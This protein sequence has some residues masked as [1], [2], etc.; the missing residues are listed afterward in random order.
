MVLWAYFDLYLDQY[1]LSNKLL[2]FFVGYMSDTELVV[3]VHH[4][5]SIS[6]LSRILDLFSV[7]FLLNS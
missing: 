4:S 1:C 3:L 7:F 6:H 5:L 2:S